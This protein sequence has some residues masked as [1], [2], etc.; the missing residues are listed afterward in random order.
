MSI[1]GKTTKQ[2]GESRFYDIDLSQDLMD[3]DY[4]T[5]VA[6]S[7]TCTT[8]PADTSMDALV[9]TATGSVVRL[10][11]FGGTS[12]ETYKLTTTATT[13]FGEVLEDEI[14]VKVKEL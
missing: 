13:S 6:L 2:P 12:G 8:T 5:S 11:A 4:V 1:L 9:H 14:I 10:F 7:V 3:G